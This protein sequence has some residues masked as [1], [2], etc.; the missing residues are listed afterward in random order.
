MHLEKDSV[1]SANELIVRFAG[2]SCDVKRGF[3]NV[4]S[5]FE[6]VRISQ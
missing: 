3:D 6:L 2:V 5:K 4:F 1:R